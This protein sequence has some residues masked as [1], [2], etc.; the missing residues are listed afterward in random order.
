MAVTGDSLTSEEMRNLDLA[1][2][3]AIATGIKEGAKDLAA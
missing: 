1:V 2:A 3:G